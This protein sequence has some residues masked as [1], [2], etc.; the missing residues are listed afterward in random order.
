[1]SFF[2]CAHSSEKNCL[3]GE[4]GGEVLSRESGIPLLGSI[5][6]DIELRK[7]GDEGLPIVIGSPESETA[8]VFREMARKLLEQ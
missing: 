6:L 7:G 8:Q 2:R 1:M 3:F 4:G 5:P